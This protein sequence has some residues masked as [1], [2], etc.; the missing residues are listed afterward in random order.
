MIKDYKDFD[1]KVLH[2]GDSVAVIPPGERAM[3]RGVV[4]GFGQKQAK[5]AYF[6]PRY[7]A[8]RE[9][10]YPNNKNFARLLEINRPY[11]YIARLDV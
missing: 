11:N 8:E 1:G 5:I 7:S 10:R 9:A 2:I 3:V 6:N 4:S